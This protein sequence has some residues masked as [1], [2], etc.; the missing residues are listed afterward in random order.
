[1]PLERACPKCGTPI[2]D[3]ALEGLC[4]RCLGRLGFAAL[5]G[6]GAESQ[7]KDTDPSVPATILK[8]GDYQLL[9]EIARGG[10]G[11]VYKARQLSLNRTVAVKVVLHGP[12]SSPTFLQ[13][14]RTEAE[15]AARLHHPN[16]VAIYEVGQHEG[17]HFLSMEYIEG[18]TL[19]EAVREKPLGARR[20]AAYVKALA[21]AMQYAH[22]QGVLHRDLKPSNVLLDPFDQ[23]RITDF[24]LAKLLHS[25]SQLTLS[26]QALGSPGHMPPELAGTRRTQ[27]QP[28]GD[29]YSLGTIL[30]HLVTGRPP[31]QGETLHEILWQV[32]NVE[33]VPP[34]RLNPSIPVDLQTIC[35]KCLQKELGRRYGSARELAQ[36]LERFLKNEPIWARP[37]SV[38]GR[39]WLWCRRHPGPAALTAALAFALAGGLAGVVREWRRAE[40]H[41]TGETNQRHL[42][43]DYAA[44]MRLNLYAADVNLASEAMQRGDYGLARRTL[45][46]LAPKEG[47]Q[48]LRGFEWRCL[49]NLCRSEEL[50]TLTGHTWIVTCAAL[51]PDGRLAVTGSQDGSARI[52]DVEHPDLLTTLP[53]TGAVWSVAFTPKGDL[54][55]TAG[56][57]G[58]CLWKTGTWEM[59]T[60]F[61]GQIGALGGDLV[62]GSESSPFYWERSGKVSVWNYR[63]GEKLSEM[64]RPGRVVALS[65]DGRLLAT[66]GSNRGIDLWEP[67]TGRLL[68]SFQTSE[69]VWSLAFSPDGQRLAAAGWSHDALVW[70]LDSDSI[71]R[72]GTAWKQHPPAHLSGHRMTVWCVAFS[73]DGK[74]MLTSSSDQTIRSW[75][76][77]TLEPKHI[78]RGHDSEVWCVACSS[79]GKMLVS[80]GKDQTVR[81]WPADPEAH[82]QSLV[83]YQNLRPAFSPDGSRLALASLEQ[84]TVPVETGEVKTHEQHDP[85]N[86]AS[87]TRDAPATEKVVMQLKPH[88]TWRLWD[89][90]RRAPLLVVPGQGD[91]AF[92]A[93]NAR[94]LRFSSAQSSIEVWSPV[95][96]ST[97]LVPLAS[98]ARGDSFARSGFVGALFFGVDMTGSIRC[99]DVTT[100]TLRATVSGPPPPIRA[101]TLERGGRFV[102]VSVER[103][104]IARLF[105][106]RTGLELRLAGHRDFVSGMAFSPDASLLATGSMD[107]TIRLWDTESGQPVATLPGHPEETTDVA[108]CPDGLTLASVGRRDSLRLWHLPTRRELVSIPMPD[109]GAFLEFSPDGRKLVVTAENNTLHVLEAPDFR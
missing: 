103:E 38:A 37:V 85:T 29:I 73:P 74:A 52:W 39:T 4:R 65:R 20:A 33:P 100:G 68:T 66:A 56:H 106:V 88:V 6:N 22:E 30:Y 10:M 98:V 44:R 102:A 95:E 91:V 32:Q 16:I 105:N 97:T 25:D 26:G 101:I 58:V 41:A 86:V 23:P 81:L 84:Q 15:A 19:A 48:E 75:D 45:V 96:R 60:N 63:T 61:S 43:E 87:A 55:M 107:G 92:S 1:M 46:A 93:D 69:P 67:Q 47:E 5:N 14:F 27:S 99:W 64:L 80:G 76:A 7:P 77:R 57:S 34:R 36:D 83:H 8:L 9:E 11:V 51:S 94:V 12:F 21:E 82:H 78:F 104:N 18:K 42:A 3:G 50:A 24:G 35:L 54:L 28:S 90:E 17:H 109:A 2:D 71:F 70:D 40:R 108:F 79:D 59:M 62:A 31:F 13:R 89:A 49:W 53:T 72:D